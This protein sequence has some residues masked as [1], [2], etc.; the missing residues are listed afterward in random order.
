MMNQAMMAPILQQTEMTVTTVIEMI[1]TTAMVVVGEIATVIAMVVVGEIA[2]G[3][4]ATV[5]SAI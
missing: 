4:V 5:A 3:T 2:T 1:E